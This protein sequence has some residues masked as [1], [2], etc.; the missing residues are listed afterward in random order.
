ML[1][2]FIGG[3]APPIDEWKKILDD[4]NARARKLEEDYE[5]TCT[6]KKVYQAINF[7]YNSNRIAI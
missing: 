3:I 4:M 6:I 5:S 1:V 7:I 2:G